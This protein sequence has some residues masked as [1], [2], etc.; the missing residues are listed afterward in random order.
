MNMNCGCNDRYSFELLNNRLF[1]YGLSDLVILEVS[2]SLLT[3]VIESCRVVFWG[4]LRDWIC[5]MGYRGWC[6]C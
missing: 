3:T 2:F 4:I 5:G 6:G 1:V